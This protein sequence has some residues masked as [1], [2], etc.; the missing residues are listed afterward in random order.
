MQTTISNRRDV[1]G[2]ERQMPAQRKAR[3][4]DQVDIALLGLM[5]LFGLV[6]PMAEAIMLLAGQ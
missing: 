6:L 1:I 4:H 5:L 3:L 2:N